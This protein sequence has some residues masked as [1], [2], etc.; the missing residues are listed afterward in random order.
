[1]NQD[2]AN[3]IR[4]IFAEKS[5]SL[6]V[7]AINSDKELAQKIQDILCELLEDN[8]SFDYL[9][10]KAISEFVLESKTQEDFADYIRENADEIAKVCMGKALRCLRCP[11]VANQ[12][13][14]YIKYIEK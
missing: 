5:P 7:E 4:S 10:Y 3:L 12:I 13:K 8:N 1:M 6:D 2:Y 14:P 11:D 9:Q